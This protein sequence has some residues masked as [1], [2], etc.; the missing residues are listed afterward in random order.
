[1]PARIFAA[2]ALYLEEAVLLAWLPDSVD[3]RKNKVG[4]L[5]DEDEIVRLHIR[6]WSLQRM[7]FK[8]TGMWF[9]TFRERSAGAVLLVPPAKGSEMKR[10]L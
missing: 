6:T 5:W 2:A 4:L 7:E 8:S 10:V 9:L 3:T 1:M